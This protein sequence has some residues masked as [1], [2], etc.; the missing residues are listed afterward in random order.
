MKLGRFVLELVYVAF[1]FILMFMFMVM[2]E[3][4]ADITVS[5]FI[6][7]NRIAQLRLWLWLWLW[8]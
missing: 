2:S 8:P 3:V 7:C 4:V 5:P 1:I 6:R